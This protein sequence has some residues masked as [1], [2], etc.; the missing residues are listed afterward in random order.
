M[1]F[2][3]EKIREDFPLLQR[4]VYNKPLIY[5]D[6]AATNQKPRQVLQRLADY[7]Q[8]EN[9]NIH[10]GTHKLSIQATTAYEQARQSVAR[11]INAPAAEQIIF[12]KGTTE[13]INLVATTFGERFVEAGD[14]IL[15]TYMEHHSNI[16]P[17]QL[18]CG[19]RGATLRVADITQDGVL[20]LDDFKRKLTTKT[21]LVAFAHVSNTLGTINPAKE[22][23]KLAHDAGARVLID[24]AQAVAHL[25]VDVQALDCDFY[26]FS[27]HKIYGPMGNGVLYGK[28]EILEEL[29]PYQGGGEMISEV[30]FGKT[31]FNELPFRFEAGTPNVAGALGLEAALHYIQSVGAEEMHQYENELLLYATEKLSAIPG[32]TIYGNSPEKT[33]VVTFNLAGIHSY[34]AGTLLDKFGIAVRTGHMCTQPL[35]EFYGVP[36]FIR[37][38]FSMYNTRQEVD[39]LA[40]AIMR[41]REMLL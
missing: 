1:N 35:T 37:A 31:T 2:D 18:M 6:N 16:V 30:T 33:G 36:G 41:S 3:V 4:T 9:S 11:F 34:D 8:S 15:I 27:A 24:G 39:A 29:P 19:R 22:L 26:C 12:T 20:D 10:R 14:E 38:S 7:Y 40:D 13:S 21:K 28:K 23:V 25:P 17:W 32:L 5:L